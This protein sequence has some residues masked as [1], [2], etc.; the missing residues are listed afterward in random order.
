MASSAASRRA[1]VTPWSL[2]MRGGVALAGG[3]ADEE[4]LG[5]DVG[6]AQ[7]AGGL[8]GEVEGPAEFA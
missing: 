8:P 2:S 6:V 4:V 5:G 3:E 1:R 7:V